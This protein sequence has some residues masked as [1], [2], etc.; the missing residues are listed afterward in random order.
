MKTRMKV[1]RVLSD[2]AIAAHSFIRLFT[3]N[4]TR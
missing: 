4:R 1:S 3:W 2:Y